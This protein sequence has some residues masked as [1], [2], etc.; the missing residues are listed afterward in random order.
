MFLKLM[1]P[2]RW[3]NRDEA[4]LVNIYILVCECVCVKSPLGRIKEGFKST[5]SSVVCSMC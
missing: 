4:F 3:T 1:R 2:V 5:E